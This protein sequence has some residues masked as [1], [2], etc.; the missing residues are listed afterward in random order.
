MPETDTM[1]MLRRLFA[2]LEWADDRALRALGQTPHPPPD[3]LRVFSHLLGSEHTWLS[4]INQ[5]PPA[6][7]VW[8]D[9]DV[10]ACG[11]LS[12]ENITRIRSLLDGL[13]LAAL[14]RRV[15]Y[16]NTQGETYEPRLDDILL[17]MCL[18][19]SY[20]R[21]QVAW[22]LRRNGLEP[23]PTDYIAFTRGTRVG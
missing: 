16:T 5:V 14:A 17:H 1:D 12:R 9:L 4:R 11:V 3:A 13:T 18:H 20:H 7:A 23:V 19:G 21:G 22:V 15:P 2:H 8:P 6:I 10:E